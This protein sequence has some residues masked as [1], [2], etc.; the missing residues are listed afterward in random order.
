MTITSNANFTFRRNTDLIAANSSVGRFY[1]FAAKSTAW[2]DDNNPP[3]IDDSVATNEYAILN[4]MLFGKFVPNS[5]LILMAKRHNWVSGTVYAQYDDQDALLFNKNFFVLTQ[6]AGAYHVFKCLDNNAGAES[7]SQPLLSET[8]ADDQFYSTSD[9]YQWKYLYS[10]DTSAYSKFAT[11]DYIPVTSNSAVVSN[12]VPG[13]IETFRIESAGSNYNSFTN[14]YFT[15][16][17]VG[18][19]TQYFGIQGSDTTIL[20]VSVNT[21]SVGELVS[22]SYSGMVANGYV[23]TTPT[24]N[25]THTILTLRNVSGVF[26]AGANVI[27]GSGGSNSTLYD[28]SSPDASSNSNFYN[29]CSIYITSGTGAGQVNHVSQYIVVG[30]ARR[31]LLSNSFT[32]IPDL[33]SKYVISPRVVIDGDGTGASAISVIDPTTKRLS[34]IQTISRGSGYNYANVSVVGNTGSISVAANSAVVR[35]VL[36][37]RGGHGSNN[38]SELDAVYYGF[39]TTFSNTESGKIPGTGSEYRRVGI[40]RNPLYSNVAIV[41]SYTSTPSIPSSNSSTTVTL[42]GANSGAH[43]I[44]QSVS[45]GSNTVYLSN[46]SGLFQSSEVLT[47][48]YSN[49]AVALS[50]TPNT[51]V[52]TI[53][54]QSTVFDN[55]TMLVCPTSTLTGGSFAVNDKIVQV[56]N[57]VDVAYAVIQSI[58]TSGSNSHIYLTEVKGTFQSSDLPTSNYKYIYDDSTRQISIEVDD[59]LKPDLV[60][61]SGSVLYV[62]NIEPV[63]RNEAQSE[64]VKL[65]IGFN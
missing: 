62:Q 9:G 42:Y 43:G 34:Y 28:T 53:T 12:A 31:V 15:D 64:T 27:H 21:Y 19:N 7:T 51:T 45:T 6:E 2:P 4:E 10:F 49:G 26:S 14:G 37:P 48:R 25:A 17:A 65:I 22:Q 11:T 13:A 52:N 57:Q 38:Y 40:I 30:N 61:Y 58:V 46:V 41:Y 3:D 60:P 44:V 59:V 23:S 39:S 18:G 63:I 47:A 20:D 8:S 36:P 29:G 16:I 54:G 35:A 24:S 32:T 5:N 55:R 1:T 33:T 56:I 50:S